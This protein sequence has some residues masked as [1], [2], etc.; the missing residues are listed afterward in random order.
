MRDLLPEQV[1]RRRWVMD[2]IRGTYLRYGFE[3]I[4][5]PALEDLRYLQSDSGQGGE[6]EKLIF[7]IL[8]R[9]VDLAQAHQVRDL[10]DYGLRFDLTVPLARY[11]ATN[12][13]KLRSPFRSFHTGPVWRAERPQRGRYRQFTQCDIDILGEESVMAEAELVAATADALRA[14]GLEEFRIRFNDRR[15]L[16]QLLAACGFPEASHADVLITVDKIDK[17]GLDGVEQMLRDIPEYPTA[18]VDALVK[19]LADAQAISGDAQAIAPILPTGVDEALLAGL[20]EIITA[21]SEQSPTPVAAL[22]DIT[23]VRGMG[24]YT[25]PVFEIE[26]PGL[27]SSIAGG[28]RYDEMIG[29]F[30]GRRVPACGFSIGFERLCEILQ[31]QDEAAVR[32]LA[33][34][35]RDEDPKGP[36]LREARALRDE[37]YV[38]VPV[39]VT[40]RGKGIYGKLAAAGYAFVKQALAE[41]PPRALHD[42]P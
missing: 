13:P 1:E 36:V 33:L 42:A 14:V 24:Y 11:Y 37:G 4:E 19:V 18:A 9:G 21:V 30:L 27:S 28:G 31:A 10:T 3:E 26:A 6:N 29:R 40:G 23:L 41:Q 2:R 15:L 38:V 17:V 12:E 35:Y 5:T 32:R 20:K 39:R 16:V 8:R 25:G 22:V 34:L 7:Q